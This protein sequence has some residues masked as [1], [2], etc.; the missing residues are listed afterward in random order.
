M[1]N[2]KNYRSVVI[3]ILNNIKPSAILDTPSGD[4]WLLNGL[5]FTVDIDG[6]DLFEKKPKGYGRF[7]N[8]DLDCGI[9]DFYG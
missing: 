5:N 6:I 4:G 8:S 2:K 3:D 9:P 1:K 7:T